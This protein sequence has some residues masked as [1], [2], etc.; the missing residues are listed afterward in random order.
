MLET[1]L[2]ALALIQSPVDAAN[3][4]ALRDNQLLRASVRNVA[5]GLEL[6]DHIDCQ[7]LLMSPHSIDNDMR[8]L[9]VRYRNMIGIP[10]VEELSNFPPLWMCEE[11]IKTNI[12]HEAYLNRHMAMVPHRAE[13]LQMAIDQNREL[14][15]PWLLLRHA[16]EVINTKYSRR[17]SLGEIRRLIGNES[18]YRFQMPPYLALWSVPVNGP[19]R[20][21]P[22]IEAFLKKQKKQKKR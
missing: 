3:Y 8:F 22:E 6:I 14:L 5:I 13:I 17:E 16:Q 10:H 7:A 12:Q 4:L 20:L 9:R 19:E 21:D 11:F 1:T 15:K 2:T 18:Y